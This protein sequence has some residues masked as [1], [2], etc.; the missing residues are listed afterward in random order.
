M[1]PYVPASD[2]DIVVS[3]LSRSVTIDTVTVEVQIYRPE[4][5]SQWALEVVNDIG[6]S[7]AWDTLFDTDA[8]AFAAFELTVEEEG[9]GAF[10]DWRDVVPFPTRH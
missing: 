9:M 10:F 1:E 7:T 3:G 2:P 6:T 5:E 8:E 4:P